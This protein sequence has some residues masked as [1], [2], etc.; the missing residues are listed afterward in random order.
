MKD[1]KNENV[2]Q[3]KGLE[4]SNEFQ[5]QV[6]GTSIAI[7]PVQNMMLRRDISRKTRVH[8]DEMVGDILDKAKETL[9][10]RLALAHDLEKKADHD[11]Y[12]AS[13]ALLDKKMVEN[14]Q[15]LTR[16]FLA[17]IPKQLSKLYDS[18]ATWLAQIED[19]QLSDARREREVARMNK[20]IERE[21]ENI[22]GMIELMVQNHAKV[23]QR[24]L[25]L[26]GEERHR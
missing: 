1:E 20:W 18:E 5:G 24:T 3:I 8:L 26:L 15:E 22:D 4:K 17:Q 2:V 16:M 11:K 6:A 7:G 19:M 10:N 13:A 12:L 21:A 25:A 23:I 9:R 14:S